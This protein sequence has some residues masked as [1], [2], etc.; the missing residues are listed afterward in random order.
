MKPK[1]SLNVGW[2]IST[3]VSFFVGYCSSSKFLWRYTFVVSFPL[4]TIV[5]ELSKVFFSFIFG[6]L[7][8][9]VLAN[10]LGC[11]KYI[12][13]FPQHTTMM[14]CTLVLV[15]WFGVYLLACYCM[16]CAV[17]PFLVVWLYWEKNCFYISPTV[18]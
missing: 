7:S 4:I 13:Y 2:F 1:M 18:R 12:C 10:E 11:N 8:Q 6:W 9:S 14:W 16:S 17:L 3:N 15:S 5:F